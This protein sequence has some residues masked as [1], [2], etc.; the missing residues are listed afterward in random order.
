MEFP[1]LPKS[2]RQIVI[3]CIFFVC[4]FVRGD[5]FFRSLLYLVNFGITPV[6]RIGL[7]AMD[8]R[9]ASSCYVVKVCLFLKHLL[10]NFKVRIITENVNIQTV[11]KIQYTILSWRAWTS[12]K[13]ENFT[14]NVFN[15]MKSS[16]YTSRSGSLVQQSWKR[17]EIKTKTRRLRKIWTRKH[18]THVRFPLSLILRG[19]PALLC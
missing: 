15:E 18:L 4:V 10:S 14:R 11:K 19:L 9:F 16:Y 5:F 2:W 7:E 6:E 17:A 8:G 12:L 1:H 3:H 13:L